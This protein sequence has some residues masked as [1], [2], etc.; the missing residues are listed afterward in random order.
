MIGESFG[1]YSILD[2]IG[3]GGMGEVFRARDE[4]LGREIALKVLLPE[5]AGDSDFRARMVHEARTASALNHPHICTVYE[6]G[7]A[8]GQVYIAMEWVKGSSLREMRA[9]TGLPTDAVV[10]HGIQIAEALAHAHEHGVVHGDLK[11]SNVVV[12]PDGRAKVLDFGLARR[13]PAKEAKEITEVLELSPIASPGTRS[14]LSSDATVSHK[15]KSAPA[16]TLFYM[17][18]EMLQGHGVDVRSDIW[19]LGVVLYELTCGHR[20]FDRPSAV[21]TSRAI[22]QEPPAPL[23]ATVPAGLRAIIQRCLTKEPERRY[24]H[25]GQVAAALEMVNFEV[26]AGAASRLGP[27]EAGWRR[28]WLVQALALGLGALVGAAMVWQAGSQ[29]A[30]ETR[31]AVQFAITL[32]AG[33]ALHD[34]ASASVALSA[35]GT[36]LAY[37]SNR[38]DVRGIYLRSMSNLTPRWVAGTEGGSSPSFSPD[39]RW[40]AFVASSELKRIPLDGGAAQSLVDT[41]FFAGASW[42]SNDMIV[43]A[44]VF[45]AGLWSVPAAGGPARRLTTPDPQQGDY[46]HLWPEVLPGATAALYTVWKGGSF[47]DAFI[48]VVSLETGE[49]RTLIERGFHARYATSGHLLFCRGGNL[50]AVPFD[51]EKL[52][53][54]GEAVPI[55]EGVHGDGSIGAVNFS[56]SRK[57]SLAY[58]P[59]R[60]GAPARRLVWVDRAGRLDPLG[61]SPR[62]YSSPRISPDGRRVAV[63]LED[64]ASASVWVYEPSRDALSKLTFGAD[65]H[66]AVWSPD[67]KQ[68][69]FESSSRTGVHQLYVQRLDGSGAEKAV[70]SGSLERYLSDWSP[71]GRWLAY[72][73]FHPETRADIW[74]VGVEPAEPPRPFLKSA[75]AEKEAVFSPD[76]GWVAYASNESGQYEVYVRPFPGPG[77][78]EQVSVGGGE[79][80]A[81]ARSGRELFYRSGGKMMAVAVTMQ[82]TFSSQRAR[83]LFSGLFHDNVVPNRTYDVAADGRFL[84]VL[85]PEA[86]KAPRQVNVILDWNNLPELRSGSR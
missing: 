68:I 64:V 31:E 50:M 33:E 49:Q 85:G 44:P 45:N 70:T 69:A 80:P 14:A 40:L 9:A 75:F 65:D 16:G 21:E 6:A 13:L 23:P 32:P 71:D 47:D 48:A 37:V 22:L 62:P 72:T 66:S 86:S 4:R 35:D 60:I 5:T 81:W 51:V 20:P 52:R 30:T 63:W 36:Q 83:E 67:G 11:S 53:V 17:G 12:T 1:P 58:A 59:G 19:A 82:P 8:D 38:G 84:M 55:L 61:E 78:K 27:Q 76:G 10:R 74:V 56:V 42:A 43:Y 41:P 24:Q 18:P 73:E 3:A 57:G 29:R 28:K 46:A 39:G 26:G 7:E 2:R 77:E 79:E 54:A 34:Y 15:R 25:A